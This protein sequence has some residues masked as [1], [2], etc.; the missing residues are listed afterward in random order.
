M[1]KGFYWLLLTAAYGLVNASA[2]WQDQSDSFLREL[3]FAQLIYAP[4]LFFKNVNNQFDSLTVKV[5]DDVLVSSVKTILDDF[6][7]VITTEQKG[8]CRCPTT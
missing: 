7:A 4:Q 3:G 8:R 6:V 5:V 1:K 2:K